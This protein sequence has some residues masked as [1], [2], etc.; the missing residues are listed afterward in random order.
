M[1]D[2]LETLNLRGLSYLPVRLG[3]GLVDLGVTDPYAWTIPEL[4]DRIFDLEEP[5]LTVI[6]RDWLAG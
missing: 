1:L 5:V 6:H 4:I 3:A 2:E